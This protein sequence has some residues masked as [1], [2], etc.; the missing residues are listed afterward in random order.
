MRYIAERAEVSYIIQGCSACDE[1]CIQPRENKEELTLNFRLLR[2]TR[3]FIGA[4]G[5]TA[6]RSFSQSLHAQQGYRNQ[7]KPFLK[8]GRSVGYRTCIPVL[9]LTVAWYLVPRVGRRQT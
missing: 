9:V 1:G 6:E 2:H 5:A 8:L 7:Q 4:A 3:Q